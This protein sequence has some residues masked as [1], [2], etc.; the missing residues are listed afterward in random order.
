MTGKLLFDQNISRR[1]VTPLADLFA[2]S[3]HVTQL[4]L[5]SN[6]DRAIWNYARINGFAIVSKDADFNQMS[7]LFGAP[8]KVIWLRLGNC[9]TGD[10]LRC[11]A[12]N[13]AVIAF[14]LSDPES[15]LLI[16]DS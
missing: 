2:G 13:E 6:E 7:F 15:A 10:I 9:A 11:L 12:R 16:L 3:R 8:P 14:F 5:G 1:V 4:R